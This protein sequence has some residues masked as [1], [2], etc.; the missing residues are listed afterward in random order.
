[1][2]IVSV[3]VDGPWGLEGRRAEGGL[4]SRSEGWFGVGR[5]LDRVLD[6]LATRAVRATFFV[7]GRVAVE[8]PER[9]REIAAA[10]HEIAHH[11]FAHLPTQALDA[12]GE[13]DELERGLDALGECLGVAPAGYRSPAWELTPVTLGLLG[14]L[15]FGYDSSLMGDDRPYAVRAGGRDIVELPVHW[16]LDDVP[17]LAFQPEQPLPLGGPDAMLAAWIAAHG[18]AVADG[19]PLT[20]TI[21]PEHTGRAPH[22]HALDALLDHVGRAGTGTSSAAE[23]VERSRGTLA[24]GAV[25]PAGD[26]LAGG[27]GSQEQ[28]RASDRRH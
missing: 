24:A 2:I 13:R 10:G 6:I 9:V 20:Y 28:Q 8:A 22:H 3:D 26:P 21:H 15:G 25:G 18:D 11:G 12:A 7:V 1:M 27:A 19:R 5:G 23:L 4:T 16:T 14:E 17:Y